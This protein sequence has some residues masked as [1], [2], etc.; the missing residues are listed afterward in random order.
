V[1]AGIKTNEDLKIAVR[2]GAKGVA[3]SS[4][5]TKAKNPVEK[6]RRLLEN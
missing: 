5:I 3:I 4:A 1:G 6:L 2:L